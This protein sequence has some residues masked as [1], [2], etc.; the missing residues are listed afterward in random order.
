[1]QP[2]SYMPFL[3]WTLGQSLC[4][5]HSGSAFVQLG[6]CPEV[7]QVSLLLHWL[8][9]SSFNVRET[10]LDLQLWGWSLTYA[11]SGCACLQL[12]LGAAQQH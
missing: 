4:Q 3:C 11:D 12:E 10:K 7:L 9:A 2:V 1:M 6:P 5:A 8:S